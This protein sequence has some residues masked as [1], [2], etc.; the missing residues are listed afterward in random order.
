MKQFAILILISAMA[1]VFI[2][3]TAKPAKRTH[4]NAIG[5]WVGIGGV[6]VS[7]T[8]GIEGLIVSANIKRFPKDF[9]NASFNANSGILINPRTRTYGIVADAG[10]NLLSDDLY[11]KE[12]WLDGKFPAGT[13]AF[14][15]YGGPS[16]G[17]HL[18]ISKN[19]KLLFNPTIG[20]S[21]GM[22]M[23]FPPYRKYPESDLSLEGT[24]HTNI[25]D[26]ILKPIRGK[27]NEI[28]PDYFRGG[29]LYN[30]YL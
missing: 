17:T 7:D 2:Q 26:L 9:Y 15:F 10:F 3:C 14:Q 12:F 27:S 1:L 8:T 24:L 4:E 29:V 30:L 11:R 18:L 25:K 28:G 23:L 19:G 22:S 5:I 16:L 6:R 13:Q 20:L 21:G